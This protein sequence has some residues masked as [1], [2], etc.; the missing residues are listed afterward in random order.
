MGARHAVPPAEEGTQ[1][2]RGPPAVQAPESLTGE[3]FPRRVR[4]ARGSDLTACWDQGRRLRTPH[5]DVAWR[6]NR[7]GHPRTGVVVPRFQFT[8]VARNRLRR[9]V[10]EILRRDALASLPAVDLVVRAKRIAYAASFADLRAELTG[11]V[12]RIT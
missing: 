1:A 10:R 9:R 5:L 4:L 8:A 2:S 3:P 12:R 7:A 11:V 6:P